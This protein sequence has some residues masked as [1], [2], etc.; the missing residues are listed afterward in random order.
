MK[1]EE[2]NLLDYVEG[3]AGPEAAA[4]IEGCKKCRRDSQSMMK[5]S[6]VLSSYSEGKKAEEE[7]EGL[8]KTIDASKMERLPGRLQKKIA[9]V[10]EKSLLSKI[11]KVLAGTGQNGG[12]L[13]GKMRSP[14]LRVTMASPKDITKTR[15]MSKK[16]K[17]A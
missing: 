15:K 5:F 1:C 11:K 8:L 10:K 2:L 7:L 17:K 13:L 16:R 14:R 12:K 3:A 6:I 4:H 9:E